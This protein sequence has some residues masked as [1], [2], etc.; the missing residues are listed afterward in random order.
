M[1]VLR[2]SVMGSE[3]MMGEGR[4]GRWVVGKKELRVEEEE[5]EAL[6]GVERLA[7]GSVEVEEGAGR[8]ED[9]RRTVRGE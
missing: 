3:A 2:R 4:E 6:E 7:E 8:L 9:I 5:E 1:K